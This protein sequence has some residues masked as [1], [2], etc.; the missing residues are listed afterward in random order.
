M[1]PDTELS[2]YNDSCPT[3]YDKHLLYSD[4]KAN[5][6][7][8]PFT[9]YEFIS[10]NKLHPRGTFAL[11]SVSLDPVGTTVIPAVPADGANAVP[12]VAYVKFTVSEPLLLSP[13]LFGDPQNNSGI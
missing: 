6:P 9:G 1:V 4:C 2:V 11:D 7:N 3:A 8:S 10:D 12:V 13:F 5:T